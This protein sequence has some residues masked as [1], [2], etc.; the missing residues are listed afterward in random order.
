[1]ERRKGVDRRFGTEERASSGL[2]LSEEPPAEHVRNAMQLLMGALD[3]EPPMTAEAFARLAEATLTRLGL[4]LATL[5][6]R[7]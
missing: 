5:E 2:W 3:S 6:N 4:A 7:R 1:V